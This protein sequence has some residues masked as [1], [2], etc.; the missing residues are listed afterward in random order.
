MLL[1]LPV[2]FTSSARLDGTCGR[3][4]QQAGSNCLAAKHRVTLLFSAQDAEYDQA[5]ALREYL[6]SRRK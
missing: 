1:L 5:V 2:S 3:R 6:I 4:F